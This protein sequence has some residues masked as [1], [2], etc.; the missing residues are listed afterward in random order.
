MVERPPSDDPLIE[1]ISNQANECY[2]CQSC[3]GQCSPGTAAEENCAASFEKFSAL[4][5]FIPDPS[6]DRMPIVSG[7]SSD[8]GLFPGF[9]T[10]RPGA[11]LQGLGGKVE[12]R[13][14]CSK[15]FPGLRARRCI[16]L[17]PVDGLPD[18]E[19]CA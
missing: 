11:P 1:K 14:C 9:F 12:F 10:K 3:S 8:P 15:S 6:L 18:W 13:L 5:T 2:I 19:Q 16:S 4:M 7:F 17:L